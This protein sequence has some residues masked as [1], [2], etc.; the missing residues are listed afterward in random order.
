MNGNS[1]VC[2]SLSLYPFTS[3]VSLSY[4]INVHGTK[5]HALQACNEKYSFQVAAVVVVAEVAEA[6]EDAVALVAEAEVAHHA[7]SAYKAKV[8]YKMLTLSKYVL[9][10]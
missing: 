4:S 9:I 8:L 2:I 5:V 1:R 10:P 7:V 6:E 3:L